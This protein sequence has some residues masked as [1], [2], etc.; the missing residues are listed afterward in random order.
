MD[1][2]ATGPRLCGPCIAAIA[3]FFPLVKYDIQII[4]FKDVPGENQNSGRVF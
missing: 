3:D 4:K 2:Y 1:F